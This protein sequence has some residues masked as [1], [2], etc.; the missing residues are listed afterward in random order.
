MKITLLR[1]LSFMLTFG[2]VLCL[3]LLPPVGLLDLK[4]LDGQFSLQRAEFPDYDPGQVVLIG[5]DEE[6]YRQLP[7]PFALWHAHLA[8]VFRALALGKAKVVGLDFTFPERSFNSV[9]PGNDQKLLQGMLELRKVAPL[10]LG[11]TIGQDGM[12]RKVHA[13]FL[14]IA[15]KQGQGYVLWRM[16]PDRVVRRFEPWLDGDKKTMP[17]LVGR[18]AEHLGKEAKAGLIDFGR[19]ASLD[20][21]PLQQVLKWQETQ[22]LAALKEAFEGKAVF[23]GTVLPFED[24]HYQPV[25]LTAWE[26]NNK[27]FVP[28]VFIHI[29]ALRNILGQGLIEP[30][31]ITWTLVLLFCFIPFW[32]LAGHEL[33]ALLLGLGGALAL[34]LVQGFLLT[35]G[36]Y[37]P[38]ATLILGLWLLLSGRQLLE[39]WLR[40]QEKHRLQAVFKGYVSPQVL[41][42][43]LE[44][45]LAP[46][47][48]GEKRRLCI[49]FSDIRGFTSLGER[50]PPEQLVQLLNRYFEAMTQAIQS[51]GGT[52]DKYIGDGIMAFFGAPKPGKNLAL[53]GFEAAKA[54]LR[55]LEELN[56][57]L[58]ADGLPKLQIGIGLHL[59]DAVVGNIGSSERNNYTAIGDAVNSASRLESLTKDLGYALLVSNEVAKALEGQ[60]EFDDLGEKAI[61]GRSAMRVHGWPP[62]H[63]S[64]S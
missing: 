51:Q 10:V 53:Q 63:E 40:L 23:I 15:G 24:R 17:T 50:L 61:K 34:L 48:F 19:H 9:I 25:N 14:S 60:A 37:M 46:G 36:T 29:Q 45:G 39:L 54:K 5:I 18:M 62:K 26:T 13:P 4:L 59:G 1:L 21:I 64:A 2:L 56:K 49:L 20:Y 3:P 43:I 35:Q 44:G 30:I 7:E 41:E 27:N 22:D 58:V 57:T 32:W 47:V 28:G 11:I 42:E 52:V 12:V 8:N 6:T 31:P 33:L 55:H 38:A 16:D